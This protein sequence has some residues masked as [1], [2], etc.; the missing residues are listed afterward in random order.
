VTNADPAPGG[1]ITV[2]I[3]GITSLTE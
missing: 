1:G 2:Q 3:R